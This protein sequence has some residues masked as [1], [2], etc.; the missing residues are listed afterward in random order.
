MRIAPPISLTEAIRKHLLQHAR[1][2]S[3]PVRVALRSRRVAQP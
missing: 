3:V 2:R 1:G